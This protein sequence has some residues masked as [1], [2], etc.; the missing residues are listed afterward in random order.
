MIYGFGVLD[1]TNLGF[2]VWGFRVNGLG[3]MV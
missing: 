3:L 2:K 1:S